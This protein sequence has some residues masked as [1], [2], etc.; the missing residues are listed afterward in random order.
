MTDEV[1]LSAVDSSISPSLQDVEV[2]LAAL[3]SSIKKIE[4]LANNDS[5]TTSSPPELSALEE[6]IPD[7]PVPDSPVVNTEGVSIGRAAAAVAAFGSLKDDKAARAEEEHAAA[8]IV[9]KVP[10]AAAMDLIR[11]SME[12]ELLHVIEEDDKEAAQPRWGSSPLA[13]VVE[14]TRAQGVGLVSADKMS[15][16]KEKVSTGVLKSLNKM[17]SAVDKPSWMVTISS[18]H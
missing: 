12:K 2:S 10:S 8:E 9:A 7:T 6:T 11:G 4:A 15:Q 3:N 13:R 16:L 17:G 14:R 5:L 1:C 18:C